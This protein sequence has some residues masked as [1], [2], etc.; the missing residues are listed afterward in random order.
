[1]IDKPRTSFVAL[2]VANVILAIAIAF[3]LTITRTL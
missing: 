3:V 1:M 2:V